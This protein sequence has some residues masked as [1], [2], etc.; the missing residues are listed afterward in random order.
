[1]LRNHLKITLRNLLR[2]KVSAFIH[3]FGFSIGLAS[4]FFILQFVLK[5]WSADRFH[6]QADRIFRLTYDERAKLPAGRYLATTSPPMGPALAAEFAEVET[7]VRLRYTDQV[8]LE[9]GDKLFYEDR[10]VYADRDFFQLFT[11]PLQ[12]GDPETALSAPN[13]VV[14]TPETAQKYFGT[15]RD[16][17]G[18]SL[19]LDGETNLTVTGVL[20]EKPRNTHLVFDFLVSFSTFKVPAGYPVTLDSWGWISFHN[21]IL[22]RDGV[23]PESVAAKLPAFFKAHVT[24]DRAARAELKLQSLE[25]IYFG[26]GQMMNTEYQEQGSRVYTNGLLAIA[27]L[28]LSIAALNFMNIS[29]GRAVRRAKEVG[30]RKV[31]GARKG[32]LIG[33]FLGEGA[34]IALVSMVLGFG[35]YTGFQ[36]AIARYLGWEL[37]PGAGDFAVLLPALVVISLLAGLGASLYP[38]LV[39]AR[40]RAVLALKGVLKT[41]SQGLNVRRLLVVFQFLVTIGLITASLV[42]LR[43]MDYMGSKQLG[44]DREQVVSLQMRTDDFHQRYR[45]AQKILTQNPAVTGI[46]AGDILDGDYGSVPMFPEGVDEH[47]ATAMHIMGGYFDYFKTL[48]VQV[49]EGRD[50]SAGHPAD[51]ATAIILNESAVRSF[52]WKDNPIGKKIR[53]DQIKEGE[54]IGVVKDFHYKSLHDPIQPLVAFVP[55]TNMEHILLRVRPGDIR[56]TILSLEKDWQEIAP[57]LPFRFSFLDETVRLRYQADERFSKLI[58]GFSMLAMLI[59]AMGLYGLLAIT[60][61]YRVREIGVRKVLGA[62]VPGLVS[63]LSADFIKLVVA[64]SGL[65]APSAWYFMQ[66]W[67]ENFEYRIEL[68]GW[69]YAAIVFIAGGAVLLVAGLTVGMQ[70]LKAAMV[71]PVKHLRDE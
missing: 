36:P 65:A 45:L 30:L 50:F 18:R 64:A 17:I 57:D 14:L 3:V 47:Q 28:I 58:F 34:L 10:L 48:G 24:P 27:F 13:S 52:G 67:L 23:Q 70:S 54:V 4:V 7:A 5:E 56:K 71:N 66:N 32:V 8:V 1:M 26:S 22:L 44:Y 63:L 9:Q 55:L 46:S 42:V 6:D 12:S 68:T 69:M 39:L 59:A 31:L 35:L 37:H 62:T 21:Y 49:L 38:A 51:T 61:Q 20:A 19:L 11:F 2:D 53:V 33:Q 43:Q 60:L 15:T 41:G 16:I 25:D 29:T 40:F